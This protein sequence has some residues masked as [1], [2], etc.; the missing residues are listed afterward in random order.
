M[1]SQPTYR[2][3]TSNK[4]KVGRN[5]LWYAYALCLLLVSCSREIVVPQPDQVAVGPVIECILGTN[6]T[7]NIHYSRVAG[8]SEPFKPQPQATILLQTA[9]KRSKPAE[10]NTAGQFTINNFRL[11]PRD[12]FQFSLISPLDTVSVSDVMP[13]AIRFTKTDTSTEAIAGIGITQVFSLQF[14]DSAV[15][16]NYY[17]ITAQKQVRKYT[18]NASGQA[19]DSITEW[20]I[21]KIDGNETPFVRNN[22]NNYTEQEIL[23]SDEIF[24]G[25]LSTFRFYN[26]LPFRNS[27]TEKTLSVKIT[28]ENL[29]LAL[30]HYYNT[31][32]EHLWS[33]KSITQLPGPV[34]SNIPNGYGVVG[35]STQEEWII[36]YP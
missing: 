13:S 1:I 11:N 17:R 12:S 34:Q 7:H 28:L 19:I 32:A 31:R 6:D 24:N 9:T 26:L 21:L 20:Q 27:K 30:Y 16:E 36:V 2:P 10:S 15:D 4:P 25:V 33:Q 23:F 22:F 14:R 3:K 18:L 5:W 35:A 29:S 8:I